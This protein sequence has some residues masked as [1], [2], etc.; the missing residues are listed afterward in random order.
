MQSTSVQEEPEKRMLEDLDYEEE[1][2]ESQTIKHKKSTNVLYQKSGQLASLFD[3][4]GRIMIDAAPLLAHYGKPEIV[5]NNKIK[6]EKM[7]EEGDICMNVS[8]LIR[9]LLCPARWI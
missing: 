6:R 7:M 4:Y 3:R 5:V 8:A 1:K 9:F 2:K